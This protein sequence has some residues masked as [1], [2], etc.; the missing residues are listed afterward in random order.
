MSFLCHRFSVRCTNEHVNKHSFASTQPYQI[1]ITQTLELNF[2]SSAQKDILRS[3]F[4]DSYNRLLKK[5]I[6]LN[7]S[8]IHLTRKISRFFTVPAT[9]RDPQRKI[10]FKRI[11]LLSISKWSGFRRNWSDRKKKLQRQR[12]RALV[13]WK[14]LE[15]FP[16]GEK[17][18]DFSMLSFDLKSAILFETS[19][20]TN[21]EHEPAI[22]MKVTR[23]HFGLFLFHFLSWFIED[24]FVP[25]SGKL[26]IN[27]IIAIRIEEL[28]VSQAFAT[29]FWLFFRCC[30]A[31]SMNELS[32]LMQMFKKRSSI[33]CGLTKC[34]KTL[35]DAHHLFNCRFLRFDY[36]CKSMK[37]KHREICLSW[38]RN[39]TPAIF[40]VRTTNCGGVRC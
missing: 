16:K 13:N 30:S 8:V 7:S 28:Q 18:F 9:H 3:R 27:Q 26:L 38:P 32:S 15:I 39:L 20:P 25:L 12:Q 33:N 23:K 29:I 5:Q 4:L 2:P 14:R 19:S 35:P 40:T 1:R 24:V 21:A 11:K 37:P 34:Y 6:S 17:R 22:A 36:K 10:P 31:R